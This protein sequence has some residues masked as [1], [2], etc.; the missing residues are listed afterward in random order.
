MSSNKKDSGVGRRGF[1]GAALSGA[2]ARAAQA[3]RAPANTY[4]ETIETPVVARHQV[5]VAGGG[6]SGV[7][8]AV[9]A[10]HLVRRKMAK[11]EG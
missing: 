9:A 3:P 7:I 2:V 4:R 6:P 10:V 1:M 8:A 5:V 11:R